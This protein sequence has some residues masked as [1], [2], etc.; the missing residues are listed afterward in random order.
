MY[1]FR[2]PP[3]L[4]WAA[5]ALI[6]LAAAWADLRPRAMTTHPYARTE[7]PAG[8]RLS[9]DLFEWR[10]VPEGLLPAVRAAG[11]AT[12]T[13]AAGEPLLPATVDPAASPA[14][15]GWWALEVPLPAEVAP[16]REVRLVLL[17][18]APDTPPQTVAG[19]VLQV[20]APGR[21]VLGSTHPPGLVA[22]PAAAA[23][24]A[25]AAVAEG[26]VSVLL[27]TTP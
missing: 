18:A 26:R 24:A 19:V 8:T 20:A 17:A 21:E 1:W 15:E 22:V 23:A 11:W 14:P 13:I 5:A 3:Y 4:R 2:R 12:R 9:D 10:R 25:A 27:S 7:I 6:V 16:G